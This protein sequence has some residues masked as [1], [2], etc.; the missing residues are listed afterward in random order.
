MPRYYFHVR[1]DGILEKDPDGTELATPGIAY[2]EAIKAA[3]EIISEKVLKGDIIGDHQF[4]IT[5]DDGTVAK[6]V[7][8]RSSLNLG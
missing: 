8:F 5:T 6:V 1:K 2:E 3:R 4:E 7:P